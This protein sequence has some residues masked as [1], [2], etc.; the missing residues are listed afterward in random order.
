[1]CMGINKLHTYIV[2]FSSV[3][4]KAPKNRSKNRPFLGPLALLFAREKN[5]SISVA[6]I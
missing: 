6:R 4:K 3:T 1:M 5:Y 2:S